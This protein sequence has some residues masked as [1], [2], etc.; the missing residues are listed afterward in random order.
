VCVGPV[1]YDSWMLTEDDVC[2]I[3]KVLFWQKYM[4]LGKKD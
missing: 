4:A 3:L 1:T 2:G